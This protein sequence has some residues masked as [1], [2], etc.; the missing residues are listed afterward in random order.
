MNRLVLSR[1][2][3]H[4]KNLSLHICIKVFIFKYTWIM[5]RISLLIIAH[6]EEHHIAK[7]LDSVMKQTRKPD[8]II[9][10]AHN[11]TDRTV[12]IASRYPVTVKSVTDKPG[13]LYARM[14]SIRAAT[15]DIILCLDGDAIASPN[16]VAE[17]SNALSGP[18]H[19]MAGARVGWIGNAFWTVTGWTNRIAEPFYRNKGYWVWGAGFGF[20]KSLVPHILEWLQQFPAVN[21]SLGLYNNPEDF[22]VAI[23]ASRIATMKV[24]RHASVMAYAKEGSSW[25]AFVRAMR[26][27]RNAALVNAHLKKTH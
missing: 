26:S 23:N 25:T 19:I 1:E 16:F 3:S 12:E 5:S 11:C 2:G 14:A 13:I 10:I 21:E 6:D 18:G 17:L 15:G 24:C 22:W 27:H 7:C 4:I 8:E 9:V 20:T